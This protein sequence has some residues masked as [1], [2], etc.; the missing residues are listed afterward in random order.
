MTSTNT[1]TP[2]VRVR[3][4]EQPA[5]TLTPSA[6]AVAQA[7]ATFVVHDER[8]RAITIKKPGVLA[9]FRLVQAV[10][11]DT[12]K[13]QVYMGMVMPIIFVTAIDGDPVYPPANFRE[14]EALIQRLDDDGMEVVMAEVSK[15][16]GK[17]DPDADKEAVKN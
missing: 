15:R 9:Q 3:T 1:K 8:G 10:G 12:A 13:N 5:T 6:E 14:V 11:P 2:K 17:P 7:A 16:F 4:E